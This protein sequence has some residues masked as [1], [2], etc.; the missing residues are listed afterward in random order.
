MWGRAL[1]VG[2][3]AGLVTGLVTVGAAQ[4]AA[5]RCHGPVTG[6]TT[7]TTTVQGVG[8]TAEGAPRQD[9]V[10]WTINRVDGIRVSL[11]CD[12]ETDAAADDAGASIVV[13]DA[14]NAQAEP[15]TPQTTQIEP[16]GGDGEPSP[17]EA[18]FNISTIATQ[19]VPR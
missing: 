17:D 4:A 19:I 2:A 18:L 9:Q 15:A 10:V 12:S 3:L 5:P 1:T 11:N 7:R 13:E 8:T 16:A 14:G 6:E